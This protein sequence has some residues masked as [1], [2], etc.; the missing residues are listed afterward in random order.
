MFLIFSLHKSV[1]H[2]LV[3]LFSVRKRLLKPKEP[4]NAIPGLLSIQLGLQS[5]SLAQVLVKHGF[6]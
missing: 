3:S 4:T 6:A 1:H 2:A 5:V